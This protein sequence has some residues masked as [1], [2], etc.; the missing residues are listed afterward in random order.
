MEGNLPGYHV[1][2]AS[3]FYLSL[4]LIV[5]VF[6]RFGR[7]WSLRNLD[8]LLLLSITPGLLLVREQFLVGYVW[9]FV[10]TGLLLLRLCC[11]RLWERRPRFEQNLNSSGLA[12][13]C[14]AAFVFLITVVI[15]QP[16][17]ESAAFAPSQAGCSHG[18]PS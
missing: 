1:N 5:A 6:F 12:F 10:V 11:D 3:W 18:W 7:V 2:E 4:I 14:F 15:T 9:L 13:L 17:P 8:L 16:P